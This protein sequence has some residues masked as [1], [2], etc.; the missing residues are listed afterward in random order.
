MTMQINENEV[1]TTKEVQGLLKI[2][3]AT[4]MRLLKKGALRV[5][6]VGHQHRF[7]GKELLKFL[8]PEAEENVGKIYVK[9]KN[10]AKKVLE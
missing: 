3:Q 5:A 2:S 6:K 8:T 1:Y 9:V 7:L 10:K 4:L